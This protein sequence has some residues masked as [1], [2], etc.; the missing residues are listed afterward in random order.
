MHSELRPHCYAHERIRLWRPLYSARTVDSAGL[1]LALSNSDIDRIKEVTARA[2]AESTASTYGSGLLI[3][4][5]FCDLKKIPEEQRAPASSIL[6]QSFV[7]ALAGSYSPSAIT[8]YVNGVRAWHIVH[9]IKWAPNKDE[10][11]AA[12]AGASSLAPASSKRKAREPFTID[13]LSQLVPHFDLSLPL[14]AAVWACTTF[15]FFS[16]ARLGELTVKNL[17]AYSPQ[18]HP[19][20]AALRK[21]RHRDG[22]EVYTIKLPRTKVS[23]DGE[24]VFCATQSGVVDPWAAMDIH[25]ALNN[26]LDTAHIFAYRKGNKLV[27]LTKF[28]AL[29]RLKTAAMAASMPALTGHSLRIGGTLEYLLRGL[30]FEAVKSIGRWQSDAF[31]LYLRRHAQVLAPY[32][33]ANPD[34]LESMSRVTLQLP[35]VR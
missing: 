18:L 33:Q 11:E 9:G 34:L 16:L 2:W 20:R 21:D 17:N 1:P 31:T 8:N 4:H 19:S 23:H 26:A 3:Y 27:P 15:A 5:V 24:D 32:M 29:K 12:I 13:I 28:T 7:A 25:L 6:I 14:D 22:S 10:L 30:S 35:P